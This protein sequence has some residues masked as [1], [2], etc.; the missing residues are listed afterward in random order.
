MWVCLTLGALCHPVMCEPWCVTNVI[1]SVLYTLLVFSSVC[2]SAYPQFTAAKG[3]PCPVQ[4]VYLLALN[5]LLPP[6]RHSFLSPWLSQSSHCPLLIFA[7]SSGFDLQSRHH[8][9][10]SVYRLP[11]L[12]CP[13]KGPIIGQNLQFR[14]KTK[15]ILMADWLW[16]ACSLSF[17]YFLFISFLFSLSLSLCSTLLLLPVSDADNRGTL[18]S[19]LILFL[20]QAS[21]CVT[22]VVNW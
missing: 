5:F 8:P 16:L 13:C 9:L 1:C 19:I 10:T 2:I 15:D 22:F 21:V 14:I 3:S 7:L 4:V 12:S 17:L 11:S 20:S 6:S 18:R